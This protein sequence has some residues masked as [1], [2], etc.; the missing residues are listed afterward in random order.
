M[1]RRIKGRLTYANIVSTLGL[2]LV[3]TGGTAM[4]I[5]GS[6]PG[7]N[8]VG[9]LDIINGEV[10]ADDLKAEAIG[11]TKIADRQVKNADLGLG[12]S[13]SNTIADG[14]IEGID[15][16]ND[17]IGGADVNES[18][19]SGVLKPD[20]V[21]A[22]GTAAGGSVNIAVGQTGSISKQFTVPAAGFIVINTRINAQAF[23]PPDGRLQYFT[24]YDGTNLVC[25]IETLDFENVVGATESGS[26]TAVYPVSAGTHTVSLHWEGLAGTSVL[27]ARQVSVLYVPSGS[28]QPLGSAC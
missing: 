22:F 1:L 8:T 12:A 9:S 7:Q 25:N 26:A 2:F 19:L 16:Q 17:T 18:T 24:K 28:G 20:D 14:G 6:L 27:F 11:T 4:A 13:S 10:T 3:L 15:I 23:S 21:Q 5:D